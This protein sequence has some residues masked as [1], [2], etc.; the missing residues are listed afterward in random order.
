MSYSEKKNK[1][2]VSLIMVN[3]KFL[4]RKIP[5]AQP[6]IRHRMQYPEISVNSIILL[7]L[8]FLC[9]LGIHIVR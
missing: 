8:S 1:T 4:A 5:G 9:L 7:S 2:L 6:K 3:D